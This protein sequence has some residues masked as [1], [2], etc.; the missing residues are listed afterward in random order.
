MSYFS[1]KFIDFFKGLAAKNHKDYFDE[2]RKT[3][4]KEVKEPFQALVADTAAEIGKIDPEVKKLQLKN[5]I[6]RINRDIRFSKDKTPYNLHVSAA[7]SPSG[8]KDMQYPGLYM[9]L[10]L[11]E[12]HFGGGI[13]VPSKENL[14]KIR[15]H[16]VDDYKGFQKALND[17]AFKKRFD[18]FREGEMNKVLP[19]EFKEYG[20]QYPELFRK[21]FFYMA[22]HDGQETIMRPDLLEFVV[23]HY[24]AGLV[25]D[26][27]FKK[28]LGIA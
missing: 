6:F 16:I 14:V 11:D 21:Q 10:S 18:G 24:K 1:P 28:A 3:Y 27:W 13:Y 15:Q 20:E 23:D 22:S 8:R 19:K 7:V 26:K 2:H 5:A 12:A 17:K 4:I 9:H 25:W